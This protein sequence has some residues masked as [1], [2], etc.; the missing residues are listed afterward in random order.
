MDVDFEVDEL[1]E[2]MLE[3]NRLRNAEAIK[4]AE[5]VRLAYDQQ[6][7]ANELARRRR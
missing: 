4:Q 2:R 5:Q 3:N 6:L 7:E 1:R